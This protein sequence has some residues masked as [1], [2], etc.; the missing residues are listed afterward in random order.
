LGVKA[1]IKHFT[2]RSNIMDKNELHIIWELYIKQ[3]SGEASAEETKQLNDWLAF[4]NKN[5]KQLE[6][7]KKILS[8]NKSYKEVASIN[9]EEALRRVKA[10]NKKVNFFTY[11][12]LI[13][14]AAMVLIVFGI[15]II[16]NQIHLKHQYIV[17][18]TKAK[19][20]ISKT[21]PDGSLITLNENS[22][23]SYNKKFGQQSRKIKLL[24]EA[25]FEV[26]K[27][28]KIP[29]IIDANKA[30]ITVLGTSFNVNNINPNKIAVTVKEGKVKFESDLMFNNKACLLSAGEEALL[31]LTNKQMI[32]SKTDNENNIAW[33]TNKLKF[34]NTNLLDA[35]KMIEYSYHVSINV[36]EDLHSQKLTAKYV[37]QP[38]DSLLRILELTLNVQINKTANS[39]YQMNPN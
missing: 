14:V 10:H 13:K 25:Y 27:N 36:H 3:Q 33:K 21:L 23:I 24:G 15:G 32:K 5:R 8:A 20:I 16:A 37:N 31:N 11:K 1:N 38:I 17:I 22:K 9:V 7:F 2:I 28:K 30:N 29:F 12:T 34:K 19:Q 6:Y 26:T 4:N 39:I 18:Q 35:I